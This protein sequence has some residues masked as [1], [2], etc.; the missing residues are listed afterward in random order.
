MDI[1]NVFYTNHLCTL[2]HSW[3]S[4]R[5]FH[6][7]RIN[8]LFF[9]SLVQVFIELSHKGTSTCGLVCR[10]YWNRVKVAVLIF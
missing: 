6:V 1:L 4:T 3:P 8:M 9:T 10:T 7:L 2:F 5:A